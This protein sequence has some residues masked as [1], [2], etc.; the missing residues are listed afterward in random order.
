M[1][2]ID[3]LSVEELR[4]SLGEGVIG[5]R[6]IVLESTRS[7]NDFLAHM[8]TPEL[9]EGLVIFAEHQTAGR[10]Q[11][12]NRWES[13]AHQ[14]L[15]FSILLRP[16]IPLIK[17]ARL[18]N[19]AARAV[20]ETIRRQT[21]LEPRIKAPNDVYLGERKIAGVLVE[22]KA[23]AGNSYAAIAGIGVNIN[24]PIDAFPEGL[25]DS[26]GSLGTALGRK[27]SRS[28]FAVA[29]LRQLDRSYAECGRMVR[30]SGRDA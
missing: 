27:I 24:Q 30:Q 17:S 20:A 14:G 7:T 25:R 22:T 1:S 19:W 4:A 18:T 8:L 26:A 15:W 12:L 10:G 3:R 21:G 2:P 5:H 16:K 11:R 6:L 28:E 9:P 29:L 13:A 23:G